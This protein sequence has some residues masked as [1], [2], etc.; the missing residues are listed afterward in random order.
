MCLKSQLISISNLIW[1]GK[2]KGGVEAMI[3][4]PD[5]K[6]HESIPFPALQY[7]WDI[8]QK[9]GGIFKT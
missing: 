4:K 7:I 1:K 3:F 6:S 8:T 2:H 9:R 5:T